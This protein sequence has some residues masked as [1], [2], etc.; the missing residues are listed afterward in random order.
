MKKKHEYIFCEICKIQ[1]NCGCTTFCRWHLQKY[2]PEYNTK[3][4]Y[5]EFIKKSKEGICNT[6][7]GGTTYFSFNICYLE[8][9]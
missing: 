4:Y 5:D 8:F 3:K 2:H 9:C 7:S 6:C 1:T